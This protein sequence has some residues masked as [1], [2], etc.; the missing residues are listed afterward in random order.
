MVLAQD[1]VRAEAPGRVAG[2]ATLAGRAGMAV[3]PVFVGLALLLTALEWDFLHRA[4]WT[5]LGTNDVPYPSYTA[6]G[7]YGVVQELNFFLSGVLMLLFVQGLAAHLHGWN[8]VLARVLLT[9]AGLAICTSVFRTDPVPGP[10]S[11][12]G[13][14]HGVSF[15][16]VLFG[17]VLGMLFGGAALRREPGWRRWGWSTIAFGCWQVLV[18]T[19]G[20]GLLPGDAG[21]YVFLLGLFGWVFLT[22]RRLVHAAS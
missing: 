20:G 19:V 15:F 11:W 10:T 8:G 4:G 14:V 16:A 13:V 7:S 9:L 5:V 22:G 2:R 1:G 18:F 21:F 17:T 6:L 3:G 12:H